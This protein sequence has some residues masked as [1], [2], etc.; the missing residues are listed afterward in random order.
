MLVI[1]SSK[2]LSNTNKHLAMKYHFIL[3][4]LMILSSISN[5]NHVIFSLHD[6]QANIPNMEQQDNNQNFLT[7]SQ[8]E[9]MLDG[10]IGEPMGTHY[11]IM[12]ILNR[13]SKDTYVGKYLYKSQNKFIK[14]SG[15]TI[16][17]QLELTEQDEKGEVTGR[18]KGEISKFRPTIDGKWSKPD[19][20]GQLSFYVTK[21]IPIGIINS[22]IYEF[23][24]LKSVKIPN[25]K[26][27]QVI[28]LPDPV[29]LKINNMLNVKKESEMKTLTYEVLYNLNGILT[30]AYNQS[31]DEGWSSSEYF[32]INLKTGDLLK[33]DDILITDSKGE[34]HKLAIAKLK[35]D[36]PEQVDFDGYNEFSTNIS[37]ID[38]PIVGFLG[39]NFSSPCERSVGYFLGTR[40][41]SFTYDEIKPF[42]KIE[43]VPKLRDGI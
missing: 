25:E 24:R 27:V 40:L 22:G 36:C 30:I 41:V 12:I 14:L 20:S 38:F 16:E 28:G 3:A 15:K 8:G 42:L 2:F 1:D 32:C 19:G 7:S 5:K 11:Y 17:N 21:I 43:L 35:E 26:R 34:L 18:F 6:N 10:Y 29:Q 37:K 9:I 23:A 13:T 33:F 4:S 31:N 39:V